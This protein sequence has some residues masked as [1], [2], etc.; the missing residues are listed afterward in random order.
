MIL[1]HAPA[2]FFVELNMGSQPFSDHVLIPHF[3]R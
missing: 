1:S 3:D 2:S